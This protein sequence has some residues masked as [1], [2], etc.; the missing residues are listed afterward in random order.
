FTAEEL[1]LVGDL[2]RGNGAFLVTDEIYEHILYD[3][4]RHVAPIGLPGLRDHVI[5][6]S[7]ASKTYSMT[8]WRVAWVVAPP[9]VTTAIRRT[10]D[11]LTVGAPHPLQMGVAAALRLPRAYYDT[12]AREY[13]E[14]RR[15]LVATLQKAGFRCQL[16]EGAYYV[17]ADFGALRPQKGMDDRAFALWLVAGAGVAGV[18]GS[19]FFARKELGRDL[20]RFHF[21]KGMPTLEAAAARLQKLVP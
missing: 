21:S 19:S 20:I 14:K 17:M 9:A 10:H 15:Y 11:F 2:C 5:M 13:D 8:G 18:P 16:P 4:R 3:G 7:G 6:V 12:L 1:Q